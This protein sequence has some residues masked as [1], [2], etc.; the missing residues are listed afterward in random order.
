M[1]PVT[2]KKATKHASATLNDSSDDE[3]IKPKKVGRP[4][5]LSMLPADYVYN[6]VMVTHFKNLN[7]FNCELKIREKC[8]KM[9][10]RV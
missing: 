3:L 7:S 6:M 1:M 10:S 5:I 4:L 2:V 8:E 9:G